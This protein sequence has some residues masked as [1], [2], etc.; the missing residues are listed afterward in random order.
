M[1]EAT[2]DDDFARE[3]TVDDDSSNSDDTESITSICSVSDSTEKLRSHTPPDSTNNSD[4]QNQRNESSQLAKTSNLIKA[5]TNP[6]KVNESSKSTTPSD[7][8]STPP[9]VK[10]SRNGSSKPKS[11]EKTVSIQSTPSN[12]PSLQSVS[13]TSTPTAEILSPRKRLIASQI[14]GPSKSPYFQKPKSC[15]FCSLKE[16][17]MKEN[18]DQLSEYSDEISR[19][20]KVIDAGNY[21]GKNKLI[22]MG[23]NFLE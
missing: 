19:L 11:K 21:V 3:A 2:I 13:Q 23:L 20:N 6:S 5:S 22:N 4:I 18:A 9:N 7:T 12:K 15:Y 16:R 8:I 14:R 10:S 17:K 1:L